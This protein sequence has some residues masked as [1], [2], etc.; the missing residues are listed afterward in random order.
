[1]K[2]QQNQRRP[3]GEGSII[4]LPNGKLKMTITI[5]TSPDGKQRRKSVTANNKTELLKKVSALRTEIAK[6]PQSSTPFFKDVVEAYLKE[7]EEL[8]PYSTVKV[9]ESIL[10]GRYEKLLDIP[11]DKIT[12]EMIDDILD[13]IVN[14]KTG[15]PLVPSTLKEIRGRLS[16]VF[17]FALRKDLVNKSPMR[18]TKKRIKNRRKSELDIPTETEMKAILESTYGDLKPLCKLAV[19]T[20]CRLGELLD[21]QMKDIDTERNTI[22][23]NSQRTAEGSGQPLKTQTSARIIYVHAEVLKE[24]LKEAPCTD[25]YL[26]GDESYRAVGM[27]IHR[28][29]KQTPEVPETFTFHTFRHYHATYLLKKGVDIKAV[30]KRL[31][32]AGITT[33]LD[34][35]AHW[36][37]EVDRKA[38]EVIGDLF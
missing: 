22:D 7:R 32:H 18:A 1:M 4:K 34:Y 11:M 37:P 10:K 25:G 2:R 9:Y 8:V 6:R 17:N 20:G 29:L 23:I 14:Q 28:W 13:N 38:S 31:G 35:Y 24:V 27:R 5:G 3:K 19:A 16:A 30:S 12:A 26:F 21:I 33:T 15:K 36:I